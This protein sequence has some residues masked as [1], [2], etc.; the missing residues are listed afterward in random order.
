VTIPRCLGICLLAA[1]IKMVNL[2][3]GQTAAP[4]QE[5]AQA[6]AQRTERQA[7]PTRDPNTAGY[8]VAKEVLPLVGIASARET[9]ERS[10][11]PGGP[12]VYRSLSWRGSP[13]V[14]FHVEL[15]PVFVGDPESALLV[16]M[17]GGIY[18]YNRER[19]G[20]GLISS[21]RQKYVQNFRPDA[22][23]LQRGH[24]V[25]GTEVDRP[26]FN[27]LLNPTHILFVRGDDPDLVKF[28]EASKVSFLSRLIPA[29]KAFHHSTHGFEI[30]VAGEDEVFTARCSK[31]NLHR[32]LPL[33]DCAPFQ[34]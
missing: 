34:K 4:A 23:P 20:F 26:V 2:V 33:W 31:R 7:P 15:V 29:E 27:L 14:G 1:L 22:A 11:G 19:D 18:L 32:T 13:R 10:R 28:E 6:P 12:K 16:K 9:H 5:T 25:K 8:V 30:E 21:V 24:H 17:A 3:F